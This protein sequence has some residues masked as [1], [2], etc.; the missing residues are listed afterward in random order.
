MKHQESPCSQPHDHMPTCGSRWDL[1]GCSS[2]LSFPTSGGPV[3]ITN[4]SLQEPTRSKLRC[5]APLRQPALLP[6][7]HH[8]SDAHYMHAC[9]Q[10]LTLLVCTLTNSPSLKT[11]GFD[12]CRSHARCHRMPIHQSTCGPRWHAPVCMR[13]LILSL[14]AVHGMQQIPANVGTVL[15]HIGGAKGSQTRY[16]GELCWKPHLQTVPGSWLVLYQQA[17]L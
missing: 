10:K 14:A 12:T 7:N 9:M 11:T 13:E 2:T 3:Q 4:G 6:T 17:R 8:W 1:Q 5:P 15:K 16:S